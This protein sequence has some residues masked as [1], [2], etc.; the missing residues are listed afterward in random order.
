MVPMLIDVA[1]VA[2]PLPMLWMEPSNEKFKKLGLSNLMGAVLWRS[3]EFFA[4]H[5]ADCS[6][7]PTERN[8]VI[9]LPRF[10][11]HCYVQELKE[12]SSDLSYSNGHRPLRRSSGEDANISVQL[13][14]GGRVPVIR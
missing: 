7:L 1:I 10:A 3:R 12:N 11:R 9:F 14:S 5:S 8:R 4:T 6:S 2:L 13:G